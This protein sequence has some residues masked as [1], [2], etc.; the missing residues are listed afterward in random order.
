MEMCRE[1]LRQG[2][3]DMN[4]WESFKSF[5]RFVFVRDDSP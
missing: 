5:L 3:Y 1:Q 2:I 4:S